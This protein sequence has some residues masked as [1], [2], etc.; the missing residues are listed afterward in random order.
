MHLIKQVPLG[1]QLRRFRPALREM[2]SKALPTSSTVRQ[3]ALRSN[4]GSVASTWMGMRT[5]IVA[6]LMATRITLN[7]QLFLITSDLIVLITIALYASALDA[8]ILSTTHHRLQTL[9]RLHRFPF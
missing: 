6:P 5:P 1:K 7:T 9:S 8:E 3:A 2:V 4:V